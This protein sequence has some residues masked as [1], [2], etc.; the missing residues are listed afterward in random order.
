MR[1]IKV[2]GKSYVWVKEE[3][4]FDDMLMEV[5][6]PAERYIWIQMLLKANE[7]G[8]IIHSCGLGYTLY[9]LKNHF[10]TDSQELVLSTLKKCEEL[11]KIICEKS[12]DKEGVERY[13]ITIVPIRDELQKK[14]SNQ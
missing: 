11:G 2:K 12:V 9:G 8:K 7:E 6:D 10:R 1:K 4:I 3:W 5:L 13:I 14:T